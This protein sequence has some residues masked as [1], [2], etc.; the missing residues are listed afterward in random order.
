MSAATG[1]AQDALAVGRYLTGLRRFLGSP[2]PPPRA[3]SQV[4]QGLKRREKSFLDL[5]DGAIYGNPASPYRRLLEHAGV[6]PCDLRDLVRDRG[7]E[8]AL[9]A[10]QSAGVYVKI[11][12]QRGLV[13]IRRGSLEIRVG[14]ADFGNPLIRRE[15][16]TA[17]GGS[18][19]RGRRIPVDFEHFAHEAGY[20]ALFLRAFG[21]ERS[22]VALWFPVPPGHAGLSNMLCH[23]KLGTPPQRWFSQYRW[24]LQ[25]ANAKFWALTVATVYGSR[26]SRLRLPRPEYAPLEDATRLARW[27]D[28]RRRAGVAA[29]LETNCSSAVRLCRVSL[30]R[31]LD[32]SGSLIR[33]GGEPF[34]E[35]KAAVLA[36]AGARAVCHYGMGELGRVGLACAE[37]SRHDDCHLALDKLAVISRERPIPGSGETVPALGFTTLLP[38]A[39]I[40]ALNLQSGDY[41]EIERRSCGC[42]VGR[43]G[44]DVHLHSIRSYEKSTSEGMN[45][46]GPELLALVDDF[47]PRRFGG[48]PTDYQLVEHERGAL[49]RIELLV[50]P[51]VADA[52]PGEVAEAALDFFAARGGSQ[53][54][55]IDRW[56]QAGAFSVVRREPRPTPAG[57]VLPL[58]LER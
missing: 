53:G 9:H 11:E 35:A 36:E 52:A 45:F 44:L 42:A 5:A 47:L 21:V 58:H 56:R 22:P 6:E 30:D 51:R 23:A 2:I 33:V 49:T 31:G 39:P 50:S 15:L 41:A 38:S 18:R 13:P 43:A 34:T 37:P 17:T 7:L 27:L 40:V 4:E 14:P 32:L 1:R 54:L 16:E 12:E 28:E 10:L 25:P 8:G 46:L 26:L 57:K 48:T 3:I 20:T 55:M 29:V 19:S 24:H